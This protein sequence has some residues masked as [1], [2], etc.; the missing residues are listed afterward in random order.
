MKLNY[1]KI[2]QG[3][4]VIMLHGVFGSS[5]N[6]LSSAKALSEDFTVFI[7]DQRNHG[8]SPHSENFTYQD[9]ADDLL[10]FMDDQGLKSAALIGHSM[11]GKTVMHFAA[12]H[13][14]RVSK[15]VVMDIS[16]RYYK[17][18]H[19]E[20]LGGL[21][22]IDPGNISSRTEADQVL[23]EYVAE[24]PVR[25]FLLK[26]LER[27]NDAFKWRINLPVITE[28]IDNVGEPLPEEAVVPVPT[29]FIKGEN[30]GYIREKDLDLIKRQ[31]PDSRLHSIQ[32]AGH[33]LHAEKPAEFVNAVKRFLAQ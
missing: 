19:D 4:P 25:Q 1:K 12:R 32:G 28:K 6:L 13:P 30:S 9:M 16:P 11:G 21:N 7:L 8:H 31:F 3:A 17:R 33:W 27:E 29:L 15:L 23:A 26:N 5:D 14:E 24:P 20:I 22:S 18:H 10:E 2:G